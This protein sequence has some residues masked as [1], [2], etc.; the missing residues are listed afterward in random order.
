MNTQGLGS[1]RQAVGGSPALPLG[2]G[3]AGGF[4]PCPFLQIPAKRLLQGRHRIWGK[5]TQF[6]QNS[7]GKLTLG[8]FHLPEGENPHQLP[9][10]GGKIFTNLSP[11]C[12][13]NNQLLTLLPQQPMQLPRWHSPP[14]LLYWGE[15][16]VLQTLA[17][18]KSHES[19]AVLKSTS[20]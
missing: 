20:K 12:H 13:Q 10:E 5:T 2:G 4:P 17:T 19:Q 6:G 11:I 16:E 7:Q 9:G 8:L 14:P 18:D 15:P 1:E 3:S